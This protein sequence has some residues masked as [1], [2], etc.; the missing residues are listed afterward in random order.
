[1]NIET[2]THLTSLRDLLTY[3]LHDLETEVHADELARRPAAEHDVTD[4][5]DEA[6][7]LTEQTMLE[8]QERRDVGELLLVRA[9]LARLDAGTYGDCAQCG[10]PIALQR[11][12][13][14]PAAPRCAAC[15][16]AHERAAGAGR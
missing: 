2:Q 8:A 5:K 13:V 16:A 12:L 15:Q 6:A 4:Q 3:R 1:M 9:A 11:L 14:E 10:E 7:R